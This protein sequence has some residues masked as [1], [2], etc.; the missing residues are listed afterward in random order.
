MG[1]LITAY[2]IL[3][4]MATSSRVFGAKVFTA[5]DAWFY[6]CRFFVGAALFEFAM[7]IKLTSKVPATR[8]TMVVI[9]QEITSTTDRSANDR[10]RLYDNY[11]FWIF[12]LTFLA[13][14]LAYGIVC[15]SH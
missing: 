7:I 10:C 3:T 9:E 4:N 11:A 2:L 12:S 15:L 8:N 14:C 1:L 6:T 13:F 5:M